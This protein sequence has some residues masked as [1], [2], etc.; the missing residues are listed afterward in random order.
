[1]DHNLKVPCPSYHHTTPDIPYALFVLGLVLSKR[2]G[3]SSAVSSLS[4]DL[5]ATF[6]VACFKNIDIWTIATSD[7]QHMS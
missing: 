6:F 3:I 4:A 5:R 7:A 1:M 2:W